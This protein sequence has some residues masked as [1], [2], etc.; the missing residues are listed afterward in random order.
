[1]AA[2]L[3]D[4]VYDNGLS[5][6]TSETTQLVICSTQPTTYT[7][8]FTTYKLGTK[9]SPTVG[10]PGAGSPNGRQVT[11]SAITDG[12]ISASGTANSL[13]LID[14]SNSRLLTSQLLS[15]TQ[16]VTSGNPFTL[17]SFTVRIPAPS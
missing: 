5:A 1:M 17:T 6:L 10:S 15:S 8:A 9:T 7:E 4:R 14:T 3:N 11:V 12:S 2:F 16:A 13:A